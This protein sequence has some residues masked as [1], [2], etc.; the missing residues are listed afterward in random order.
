MASGHAVAAFLELYAAF[1]G[2]S[3]WRRLS[4][5]LYRNQ[6]FGISIVAVSFALLDLDQFTPVFPGTYAIPSEFFIIVYLVDV[7]L[8][9]WIDASIL[10][11]KRTDPLLRDTLHWRQLRLVIWAILLVSVVVSILAQAHFL[12]FTSLLLVA[13]SGAV[14]LPVAASRSGDESMRRQLKWFGLFA[15]LLLTI[16]IIAAASGASG[17]E[18]V[19]STVAM[20]S[21]IYAADYCLY[22]SAKSLVPL[23]KLSLS[24][25]A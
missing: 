23:N 4:V 22:K 2:F 20:L 10:A 25:M 18:N 24:D 14:S 7:V 17:V 1:W 15:L 19:Y 3:I 13:I 9:Y 5:G 11:A 6:A 8:F 21:I 16:G 12:A